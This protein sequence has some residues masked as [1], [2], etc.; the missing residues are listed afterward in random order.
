MPPKIGSQTRWKDIKL[1]YVHKS[2][3]VNALKRRVI[4]EGGL[5]NAGRPGRGSGFTTACGCNSSPLM[6]RLR[7]TDR[8]SAD[9]GWWCG[10]LAKHCW[11]RADGSPP[12]SNLRR[13]R[14]GRAAESGFHQPVQILGNFSRSANICRAIA[15]VI[16]F[17]VAFG[18]FLSSHFTAFPASHR[19]DGKAGGLSRWEAKWLAKIRCPEFVVQLSY[20]AGRLWRERDLRDKGRRTMRAS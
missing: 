6:D 13:L 19:S 10:R 11:Q 7:P 5:C 14:V 16:G 18:L 4:P 1:S 17:R 2:L 20:V 12:K 9:S 3:I 15:P 8:S